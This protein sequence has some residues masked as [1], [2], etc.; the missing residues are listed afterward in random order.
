MR[1]SLGHVAGGVLCPA[2]V[3]P[4]TGQCRAVRALWQT[5]G[6]GHGIENR[7][8]SSIRNYAIMMDLRGALLVQERGG[9]TI[10]FRSRRRVGSLSQNATISQCV[11][12]RPRRSRETYERERW[13]IRHT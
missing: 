10:R 5:Y 11:R 7:A 1:I 13:V 8:S 6:A 12:A 2:A 9:Q 3:G 4:Y